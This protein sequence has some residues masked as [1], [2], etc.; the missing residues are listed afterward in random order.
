[1]TISA[2]IPTAEVFQK[3]GRQ[4]ARSRLR[5]PTS[6]LAMQPAR[7]NQ[8]A[9]LPVRDLEGSGRDG[10][11]RITVSISVPRDVVLAAG[12]RTLRPL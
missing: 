10:S 2:G 1:M 12:S 7:E 6:T 4:A 8:G 3:P 9:E 5:T 11:I